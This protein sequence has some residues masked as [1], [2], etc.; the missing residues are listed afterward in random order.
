MT[1]LRRL[2]SR[3]SGALWTTMVCG[4]PALSG[5]YWGWRMI[6]QDIL[7]D[8]RQDKYTSIDMFFV[9]LA[10]VMTMGVLAVLYP[11]T[12]SFAMY[13]IYCRRARQRLKM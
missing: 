8:I 6:E 5:G 4:P 10:L 11:I 9:P 7:K 3:V 13:D 12:G 2:A 1:S